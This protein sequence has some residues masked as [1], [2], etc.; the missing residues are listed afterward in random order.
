MNKRLFVAGLPF[1][2]TTDE[3]KSLFSQF[4]TVASANIIIDKFTGKSKG[5]GFVE[6]SSSEEADAALL[7]LNGFDFNGRKIVVAEAKPMEKKTQ[8]FGFKKQSF[9]RREGGRGNFGRND[10]KRGGDQ[11]Q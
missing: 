10:N 11:W 7:K 2:T 6:M 8:K 9:G 5:F 4:G 1:N 3:L